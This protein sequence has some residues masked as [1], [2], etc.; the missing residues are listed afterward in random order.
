MLLRQPSTTETDIIDL[1]SDTEGD[2]L[3]LSQ[4]YSVTIDLINAQT[5]AHHKFDVRTKDSG[6]EFSS[7]LNRKTSS[8]LIEL[9]GLSQSLAS[10]VGG[11]TDE[12]TAQTSIKRKSLPPDEEEQVSPPRKKK[13]EEQEAL[14]VAK[15]REIE[16]A[17]A[18][19]KAEAETAKASKKLHTAVNKLVTD[20]KSLVKDFTLYVSTTLRDTPLMGTVAARLK[21]HDCSVRESNREWVPVKEYSRFEAINMVYIDADALLSQGGN[22]IA[23]L[24][25]V[26]QKIKVELE[27]TD[28][29]QIFIMIDDMEARY[30]RTGKGSR[31]ANAAAREA[32]H[33][34]VDKRSVERSLASLQVSQKCFI[35]HVEGEA[36]A[37][38]W[39]FNMTAEHIRSSILSVP[40]NR[41]VERS[42]LPF[43][44]VMSIKTGTDAKD[45]Y[46]KM[47]AELNLV[48]DARADAVI[49]QRP[50]LRSLFEAYE[51]E[52]NPARRAAMLSSGVVDH[53][54]DGSKSGKI[55]NIGL[56]SKV[57]AAF[58]NAD[59]LTILP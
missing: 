9:D 19:K 45:T 56:S 57:A 18:V 20:K 32:G 28:K 30:R 36:D 27:L 24:E 43:C 41:L 17:K 44:P 8:L 6:F 26:I 23:K 38:E 46:R 7:A 13:V 48:S 58:W 47:L 16:E 2:P 51:A 42:H 49:K 21:E 59:S 50:T 25:R 1:S 55:L 29:H 5:T 52:P 14:R 15:R 4:A 33:A 12:T 37:A 39:I 34:L 3:S 11:A 35:V 53:N 31:A 22:G 54:I 40:R 10:G